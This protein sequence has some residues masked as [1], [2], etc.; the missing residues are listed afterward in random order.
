M[1]DYDVRLETDADYLNLLTRKLFHAGFAQRAVNAKWPA[2]EAAFIG[3]EPIQVACMDED[4]LERLGRNPNIVRNR[5]KLRATVNNARRFCE[6]AATHGSWRAWFIASR[7]QPYEL[8]A[9]ALRQS[10]D[11]IGPTTAFYFMLEA[12]EATLA[13]KPEGVQ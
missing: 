8:R 9:E 10:L 1:S 12:G 11:L 3:F 6:V 13:D 5:R 7:N 4:D 2:F